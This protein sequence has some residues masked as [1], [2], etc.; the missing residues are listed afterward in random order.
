[1]G[2]ASKRGAA[3]GESGVWSVNLRDPATVF[4]LVI[5]A[6]GIFSVFYSSYSSSL[7]ITGKAIARPAGECTVQA[8]GTSGVLL[9]GSAGPYQIAEKALKQPS[10]AVPVQRPASSLRQFLLLGQR[11][12]AAP[13]GI[14]TLTLE[15]GQSQRFKN[16]CADAQ[17]EPV[18]Q[19]QKLVTSFC[20]GND[21]TINLIS[22]SCNN[23]NCDNLMPCNNDAVC[24]GGPGGVCVDKQNGL[25]K[26]CY[27]QQGQACDPN[28]RDECVPGLVCGTQGL[29]VS[30]SQAL[31]LLGG[32]PPAQPPVQVIDEGVGGGLQLLDGDDEPEPDT[33]AGEPGEPIGIPP[34]MID[35]DIIDPSEIGQ[36]IPRVGEDIID[37]QRFNQPIQGT[38]GADAVQPPQ[39][40][41]ILIS[42][43]VQLGDRDG[44]H[45][46]FVLVRFTPTITAPDKLVFVLKTK[47]IVS[48]NS[49][50][51]KRGEYIDYFIKRKADGTLDFFYVL[52]QQID[53]P[54]LQDHE[55]RIVRVEIPKEKFVV[56][57]ENR[58]SILAGANAAGNNYDDFSIEEMT[59][60][61]ATVTNV[62]VE[63]SNNVEQATMLKR[64]VDEFLR[65]LANIRPP[66][67]RF[68]NVGVDVP[69]IPATRFTNVGVD[70]PSTSAS[71]P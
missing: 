67:N 4:V 68:T 49:A 63:K 20:A 64:L 38:G 44:N 13:D 52:N 5:L 26:R 10:C 30:E 36:T 45:F 55:V 48:K 21:L 62:R 69:P 60:E 39:G 53:I 33:L 27:R 71:P 47:N 2:T 16:G 51:Y 22:C 1:M 14:A 6:F 9:L 58:I 7:S 57:Q 17:Y 50:E 8:V 29:C 59:V 42:E 12:D 28:F 32:E 66:I 40:S 11:C 19:S 56:G 15:S 46:K 70:V 65:S 3:Q 61:G 23:G 43:R 41:N 35:Q 18:G 25:G 54:G 31:Q 37:D 34:I 24:A